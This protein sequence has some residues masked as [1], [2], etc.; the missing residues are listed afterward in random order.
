AIGSNVPLIINDFTYDIDEP[1]QDVTHQ[2]ARIKGF[3]KLEG[4]G[5]LSLQYDFQ[6]NNRLEYDIRRGDDSD[7]ASVDLELDTH[8][9][10]VDLDASL[11]D[12]IK[13]KTGV[14]AGYQDNFANPN[15]GV[16]RLIPDYDKYD[17]GIYAI[18]DYQFNDDLT[19]EAGA[20]FDYTH[21][22]V[23]KFYRTSFWELRNYDELLPE[24]VV[25]E[26]VNQV[27]TNPKLN[28]NNVSAT[29]GATYEFDE[30]NKLFFNYSLASRAPNPSELFSEGL[31]HSA[32]RIELGDLTFNSE[33]GHKI[34]LT[35]QHE[36]EKFSFSINPF[37]N[38]IN[39]FIVI[40]PTSVQQTVRGNFQVWEYRQTDAQLLGVDIDASYVFNKNFQYN[41]QLSIVKGYDRT[42]DEP[43]IS[44]PPVN[45]KNE[46][47]YQNSKLNNLRLSLQSEYVFRQNE[48]PD[49]NFEVYIP[50]TETYETI[51]VSTPPDAYHLLNF[52]SSID[53]NINKQS[54]LTV[55]FGVTN[56][57]NTSYRNYLNRLRYYADDL[58]R[59]Y[60]LNI[61]FNY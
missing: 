1:K 32:S 25:E 4:F 38:T 33:I 49:N 57:F 7:K 52:N 12:A 10:L 6:R 37:I 58:G 44:M 28:F 50:T 36:N 59:N 29:L 8:T 40:E 5:K 46:I 21:M 20:R 16:R 14:V 3:K 60:L 61:K 26:L 31:H 19:L 22:D 30:E 9:L 41:H 55:G 54:N 17:L 18:V 11:T 53:F 39:D 23:F 48:Y 45:T 15:T 47:V 43:L 34:G 27:L 13:L 42:F 24:I 56:V 51:D 2:L 35:F